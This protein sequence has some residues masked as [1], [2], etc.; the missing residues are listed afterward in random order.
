M[1][2]IAGRLSHTALSFIIRTY[3]HLYAS[4]LM[5]H[6]ALCTWILSEIATFTRLLYGRESDTFYV[7]YDTETHLILT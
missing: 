6:V 7:G 1:V 2:N 3:T 4:K 5:L